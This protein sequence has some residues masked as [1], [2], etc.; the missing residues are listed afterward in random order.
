MPRRRLRFTDWPTP[1]IELADTPDPACLV[2]AGLGGIQVPDG[3]ESAY[4]VPCD[5]WDLADR[6]RILPLPRWAARLFFGWREPDHS[7]TA[8]F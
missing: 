8:P 7:A 5:C 1:H 3:P 2:C 4:D 6:R